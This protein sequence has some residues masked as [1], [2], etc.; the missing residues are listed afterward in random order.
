MFGICR[1]GLCGRPPGYSVGMA[2]P[3]WSGFVSFGL[4]NIPIK[5][6]TAVR[7]HTVH[8]HQLDKRTGARVEYRKVSSKSGRTLDADHIER[9]FEVS[10]GKYV[11]IDDDELEAM[12]PQSTKSID[13][14]EFVELEAVD[15]IF[16]EH[17]YWLGADGEGASRAYRLLLAAMEDAA[18]VGIG[19]VVMRNKQYLAAIRPHEHALVMS[20]M[21]FADEL[22]PRSEI[23]GVPSGRTKPKADELRLASSIVD[24]LAAEWK[25]AQYHDTY[26]EELRGLIAAKA[27]GKSV[28]VENE[29]E[30]P[31][32]VTDLM[33]ALQASVER[34]R[35]KSAGKTRRNAAGS[36]KSRTRTTTKRSA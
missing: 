26:A 18:R 36:A 11:V 1:A 16:Y 35:S 13:I 25:P 31:A 20:T 3:I 8:F 19:T 7:D 6:Y 9:G 27:K 29:N 32:A 30:P 23:D 10:K 4:V 24:A 34:H 2:R 21:R 33:E 17:T 5:A 12:R 14:T 15:P 28:Q 22:V